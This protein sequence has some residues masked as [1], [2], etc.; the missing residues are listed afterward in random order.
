MPKER[1][2]AVFF[3]GQISLFLQPEKYDFNTYK[4][5]WETIGEEIKR[6]GY[7]I[8]LTFN[9]LG[10]I[11]RIISQKNPSV[12]GTRTRVAWVKARYPNH[13]DYYGWTDF[14][15]KLISTIFLYIIKLQ[16]SSQRSCCLKIQEENL[17]RFW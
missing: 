9:P 14:N 8:L 13:L 5:F 2:E 11:K 10:K 4:G 15:E 16:G 6:M 12:T 17:T 1:C 7:K 3:L